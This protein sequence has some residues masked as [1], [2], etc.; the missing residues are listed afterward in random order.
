MG[1]SWHQSVHFFLCSFRHHRDQINEILLDCGHLVHLRVS[2]AW[3]HDRRVQQRSSATH[4]PETC[5]GGSLIVPTSSSVYFAPNARPDDLR[6]AAF[7]GSENVF[8]VRLDVELQLSN[9]TVRTTLAEKQSRSSMAIDKTSRR[10]SQF[11]RP[12]PFL[13]PSV[14]SPS[15]RIPL[16]S[17]SQLYGEL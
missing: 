16:P 17:R 3:N 13:P 7:V 12:T 2:V 9:C 4:E 14:P 5:I 6:Q 1:I 10:Y 15:P 8:V 11:H